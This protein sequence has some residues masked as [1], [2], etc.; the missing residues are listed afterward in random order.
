MSL[1]MEMTNRA[2]VGLGAACIDRETTFA[3]ALL[4][5]SAPSSKMIY[6]SSFCLDQIQHCRLATYSSSAEKAGDEGLRLPRHL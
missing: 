3:C 2:E 6:A 1:I 4:A 5:V